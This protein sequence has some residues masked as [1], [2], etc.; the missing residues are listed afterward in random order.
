MKTIRLFL[1]LP[2][3]FYLKESCHCIAFEEHTLVLV[4]KNTWIFLPSMWQYEELNLRC[5]FCLNIL[6]HYKSVVRVKSMKIVH[7]PRVTQL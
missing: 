4:K 1:R 3:L 6:Y 7:K 5:T 2:F